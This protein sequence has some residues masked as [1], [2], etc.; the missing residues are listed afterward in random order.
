MLDGCRPRRRRSWIEFAREELVI[1]S[2]RMAG[3]RF[4]PDFQP[5]HRL[6][7]K[8]FDNPV[9]NR[10]VITGPS[11]DG[12]SLFGLAVPCMRHLFDFE[13]TVGVLVP[14]MELAKEK[15]DRDFRP[16]IECSR[17]ASL[18]PREGSGSQGGRFE[19]ITF[20]NGAV[21]KFLSGGGRDKK[22]ASF[23]TQVL[24]VTETDGMDEPGERSRESDP[25]TQAEARTLSFGWERRIYLECTVSTKGGRIWKEYEASSRGRIVRR[26]PYCGRWVSPEREHLVGWQ[27]ADNEVQADQMAH[28]R[29]PECSHPWSEEDRRRANSTS[30]IVHRGQEVTPEGHIVG[31]VTDTRTCGVRWSAVDNHFLTAGF[32]GTKEWA[33]ARAENE[34]MADRELCQFFWATPPSPIGLH[35]VLVTCEGL[36]GRM[37]FG[38]RGQVPRDTAYLTVGIDVGKWTLHWI[39]V[40]WLLDGRAHVI[41]YG[42]Q[43]TE[44]GA[45]GAELAVYAALGELAERLEAGFTW[46]GEELRVPD[47]VWIDSGYLT[48]TIYQA[49][50]EHAPRFRPVKG[51]GSGQRSGARYVAPRQAGGA[52]V[53][54]GEQWHLVYLK[55]RGLHIVELGSDYWKTWARERLMVPLGQPGGMTFF[56]TMPR[57]HLDLTRQLT[58]EDP[59][60]DGKWVAHRS[61][62]HWNDALYQACAAANFC[63]FTLLPAPKSGNEQALGPII[64]PVAGLDGRPFLISQR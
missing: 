24:L 2:G 17:Y 46:R 55:D 53:L 60:A 26:C 6:L 21:L 52:V 62:N 28:F 18:L 43:K 13:Q 40:A 54:T 27:D 23:T 25:I 14:R 61:N 11:Q 63:G 30:R 51:L 39:A 29:C 12:K 64:K 58:A 32:I 1:P 7:L 5:S 3:E 37:G 15:W 41:E 44:A 16:A 22:R 4:D 9:W 57:D 47:Q 20:R 49:C 48:D 42:K 35:A 50:A 10:F 59:D 34:E 45:L 56:K 36:M 31:A 19:S 33:A 38:P 8:E